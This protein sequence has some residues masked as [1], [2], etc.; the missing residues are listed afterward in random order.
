[1]NESTKIQRKS[2]PTGKTRHVMSQRELA[3][4]GGGQ[5]AYIKALS[6]D[7]AIRMFPAIRGLPKGINLYALQAADGTPIALTD[8][9]QAAIGHA[10]GDELEIASVH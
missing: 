7:E 1:M 3:A 2:P 9:L 10:M 8:T 5:V 4:L 6:S